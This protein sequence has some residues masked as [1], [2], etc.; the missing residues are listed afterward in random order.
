MTNVAAFGAFVDVG[1]HQ[2]GLVHVSAM[3]NAFVKDPR[4]VAKPGDVV[5]VKVLSVDAPRKRIALTMRL[6]DPAPAGEAPRGGRGGDAK[7]V[8]AVNCRGQPACSRRRG[9]GG[10]LAAGGGEGR[11]RVGLARPIR[12]GKRG[13]PPLRS[14][15]GALLLFSSARGQNL[16]K[17]DQP[18]AALLSGGPS[19]RRTGADRG[20]SCVL[21][22]RLE[23]RRLARLGRRQRH[24]QR[25]MLFA[26]RLGRAATGG[27]GTSVGIG[28]S[29]I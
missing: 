9:A 15:S 7:A 16:S 12:E 21:P 24:L 20:G 2:D 10:G 25:D 18:D 11:Q 28:W 6:S 4:A 19:R 23:W 8:R 26:L 14:G 27:N 5:K 22:G 1:V 17:P 13:G 3:A 29:G